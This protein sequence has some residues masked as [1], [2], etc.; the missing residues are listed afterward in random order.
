MDWQE[1]IK[2]V[3]EARENNRLVIFVGSGVSRNSD[4]PTWGDLIEKI[5]KKIRYKEE[6]TQDKYLLIPEYYYLKDRSRKHTKYYKFISDALA[7]DKGSNAIDEI[8]FSILPEH[9]ITTNYDFL[10][11]NTTNPNVNMYE[12]IAQDSDLLSKANNRYIIKMHGSLDNPQTI[13]LKESDYI[14]YEQNHPLISTYIRSLLINHTFLFVGYSLNDNNLNLIIGW[15]EYFRKQHDVSNRPKNILIVDKEPTQF[16]QKRLE[17]KNIFP[18]N[19]MLLPDEIEEKCIVP[20]TLTSSIG[21]K[22]YSYFKCIYSPESLLNYMPFERIVEEK[23]QILSGYNFISFQDLLSVQRLGN[24]DVYANELFFYE[25]EWFNRIKLIINSSNEK[26]I[27]TLNKSPIRIIGFKKD[28]VEIPELYEHIDNLHELFLLND[29]K[30]LISEIENCKN[31]NQKLFYSIMVGKPQKELLEIVKEIEHNNQ[32][33]IDYITLI[34]SKMSIRLVLI[35]IPEKREEITKEIEHIFEILPAKY[36]DSTKFLKEL[37]ESTASDY[38]IMNDLLDKVEERY[39]FNRHSFST[40]HSLYNVYKLYSYA[41]NYYNYIFHN[42]YPLDPNVFNDAKIYLSYYIKAVLCTYSPQ[43]K[44][45]GNDFFDEEPGE[46][47]VL[48]DFEI[49]IITKFILPSDLSRI[50]KKYSINLLIIDESV[51]IVN[52]IVNLCESYSQYYQMRLSE[53]IGNQIYNLSY[54]IHYGITNIDTIKIIFNSFID[55]FNEVYMRHVVNNPVIWD[56]VCLI[57]NSFPDNQ[58]NDEKAKF[59]DVILNG[60]NY[61]KTIKATPHN[62]ITETTYNQINNNISE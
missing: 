61:T 6:I 15:I 32:S 38:K 20:N 45:S 26:I 3:Q 41:Y 57:I 30:A 24:V 4:I 50:G 21:R 42:Y 22:I 29:Y 31:N 8:I 16:E 1:S 11:E 35:H 56:A 60:E 39:S 46:K 9:I 44:Y 12:V 33:N 19:I 51:D 62:P 48:G 52:K 10:L 5:A 49:E 37:F 23:F 36:K 25:E 43:N 14:D 40:N 53:R 2:D 27:K 59:I 17:N 18:I 34:I 55:M 28:I 54:I 58:L 13:V 7:T 47:Y